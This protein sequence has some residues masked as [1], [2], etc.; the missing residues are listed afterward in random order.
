MV[1]PYMKGATWE[2]KE[3]FENMMAAKPLR[4]PMVRVYG[5]GPWE[6]VAIYIH[7]S[8]VKY[9][10]KAYARL[11]GFKHWTDGPVAKRNQYLN[12]FACFY[13]S[14]T[15]DKKEGPYRR[16]NIRAMREW[17]LGNAIIKPKLGA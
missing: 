12:L 9:W 15:P 6:P 2:P 5:G 7:A 4:G 16:F 14:P 10:R 1:T 17:R 13:N 3:Y 11:R 8:H